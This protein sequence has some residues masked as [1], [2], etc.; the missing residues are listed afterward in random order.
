MVKKGDILQI[1]QWVN[2]DRLIYFAEVTYV[3]KDMHP[4]SK[5]EFKYL[6]RTDR[7]WGYMRISKLKRNLNNGI[8]TILGD[9]QFVHL[10]Q[11]PYFKHKFLD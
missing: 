1:P 10:H 9:K 2:N 7:G 8:V 4:N 11:F 6:N 5:V 3:N